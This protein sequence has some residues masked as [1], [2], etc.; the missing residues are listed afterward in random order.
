MKCL[1]LSIAAASLLA[2]S[3]AAPRQF[4]AP[5]SEAINQ[6]FNIDGAE[7][8]AIIYPNTKPA[9]KTGAQL[10]LGFHSHGGRAE[11]LARR[12]SLH[13]LWRHSRK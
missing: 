5:Q 4:R 1:I 13:T 10:A 8:A 7:R 12:W 2:I 11:F 3:G 6:T 9:P